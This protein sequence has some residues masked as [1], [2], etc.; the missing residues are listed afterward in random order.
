MDELKNI[1][2]ANISSLRKQRSM[3]QADLAD[4]LCY[5]DKAISKWERG[6]SIPDVIVLKRVADLF[7]VTVDYLLESHD[8]SDPLPVANEDDKK[9]NRILIFAISTGSV[10]FLATAL[11]VLFLIFKIRIPIGAWMVFIYAIPASLTVALVFNS[12]WGKKR[13]GA[14]IVSLLMWSVILAVC[15]SFRN[16][17]VWLLF[18]VGAPAQIVIPMCF[19]IGKKENK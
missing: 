9:K 15:L 18:I 16:R 4:E 6:E 19:G 2:A 11:F 7:S 14:V 17:G 1:I 12:I 3:T 8:D 13:T 10:W 5:S